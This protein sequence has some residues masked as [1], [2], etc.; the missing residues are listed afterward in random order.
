MSDLAVALPRLGEQTRGV[1]FLHDDKGDERLVVVPADVGKGLAELRELLNA[2][3]VR[4]RNDR[5]RGR[6][7]DESGSRV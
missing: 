1:A 3:V 7:R 2:L 4:N 6:E 5:N